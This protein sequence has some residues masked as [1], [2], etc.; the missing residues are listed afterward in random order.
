MNL[1]LSLHL[2]DFP[3]WLH[4]KNRFERN[5]PLHVVFV[6]NNKICYMK[7]VYTGK[8]VTIYFSVGAREIGGKDGSLGTKEEKILNRDLAE[9]SCFPEMFDGLF[10]GTH[11]LPLRDAT[12]CLLYLS[13]GHQWLRAQGYRLHWGNMFLAFP[14]QSPECIWPWEHCYTWWLGPAVL[15]V[16]Y[17]SHFRKIEKAFS[18]LAHEP[19]LYL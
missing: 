8:K 14:S 10:P 18:G 12:S 4:V 17:L 13:H 1:I 2:L 5:E 6:T 3:W 7:L 19:I 16:V 11:S 9:D 15:L